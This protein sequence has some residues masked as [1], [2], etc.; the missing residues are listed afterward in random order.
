LWEPLREFPFA[1][2][3]DRATALSVL[4]TG[5]ARAALA[6]S[7]AVLFDAPAA[8]SGK[9]LL[10]TT[11][12]LFAGGTGAA[13]AWPDD[14]DE[15][16]KKFGA[17]VRE[18]RAVVL[19]DNVSAS[20]NSS[21]LNMA[22]TSGRLSGRILGESE[23][24]DAPMR[25]LVLLTANNGS[26]K[27]DSTRRFLRVRIDPRMEDPTGRRFDFDP[28]ELVMRHRAKIHAAALSI[29]SGYVQ[30]GEPINA[31]RRARLASFETWD[32][33]CCEP[34]LWLHHKG[35]LGEIGIDPSTN[36]RDI[37]PVSFTRE[38]RVGD[39][40]RASTREILRLLE[41][42]FPDGKRFVA[43]DIKVGQPDFGELGEELER[44]LKA[45]RCVD[46]RSLGAFLSRIVDQL[47]GV[48]S[49]RRKRLEGR[50]VFWVQR[51]N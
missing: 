29:I 41:S 8:G 31:G 7:P 24:F 51:E 1:S 6:T 46:T 48:L 16:R 49:L 12:S 15:L 50:N 40:E 37:D 21:V 4:L 2:N 23:T 30:A 17:F 32:K 44:A 3:R 39:E 18:G 19:F 10:A 28:R 33:L 22:L 27:G 38:A 14:E 26:I 9:T 13:E 35:L 36:A 43:A 34:V 5:A 42:R 45:E 47:H 11:A 25:A 20:I